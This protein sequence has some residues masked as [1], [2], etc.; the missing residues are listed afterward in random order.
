VPLNLADLSDRDLVAYT[1]DL[2]YRIGTLEGQMESAAAR[3]R[4][5]VKIVRSTILISGG[6]LG[7]TLI[8]LLGLVIAVLGLWDCIEAIQ[9]DATA[10]NRQREMRRTVSNLAGEL[11][12]VEAEFRRR[13][14]EL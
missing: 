7:A 13:G 12:A 11:N 1:R 4:R 8:D 2:V 14:I 3:R 9:D 5:T 10:M 6:L